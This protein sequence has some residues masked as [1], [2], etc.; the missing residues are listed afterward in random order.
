MEAAF[1]MEAALKKP[2]ID[3]T[4][5]A[6]FIAFFFVFLILCIPGG[7]ALAED[8][9]ATLPDVT[10]VDAVAVKKML[11]EGEKP[12]IIDFRFEYEYRQ[13]SLPGAVNC[14]IGVEADVSAKTIDKTAEML[15]RCPALEKADRARKVV[16]FCKSALCWM[17]PKGALAL[18]KMGFTNIYWFRNGIREWQEKQFPVNFDIPIAMVM[19]DM[20]IDGV[21]GAGGIEAKIASWL[22]Q[23]M[24]EKSG[25]KELLTGEFKRD[26]LPLVFKEFFKEREKEVSQEVE[27]KA[28][29]WNF[30][31]WVIGAQANPG[32]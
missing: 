3:H 4:V 29:S 14:L 6:F 2:D 26:T 21:E 24:D 7:S 12:L 10:V 9:P 20:R 31:K 18:K 13:F 25:R 5:A 8:P 28:A 16:A 30:G 22:A 17:S 32:N 19:V 1:I 27:P 11:D 15:E 23:S